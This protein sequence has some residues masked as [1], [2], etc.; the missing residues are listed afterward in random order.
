MY[1][2]KFYYYKISI[3]K[4]RSVA[5]NLIQYLFSREV[6]LEAISLCMNGLDSV[7]SSEEECCCVYEDEKPAP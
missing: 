5:S 3:C 4:T 1:N 6:R 7:I 2:I